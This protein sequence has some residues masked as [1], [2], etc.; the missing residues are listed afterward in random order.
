MNQRKKKANASKVWQKRKKEREESRR[1]TLES[2]WN[3]SVKEVE[4]NQMNEERIGK[5]NGKFTTV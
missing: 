3:R 5:M 2:N 1:L 4:A